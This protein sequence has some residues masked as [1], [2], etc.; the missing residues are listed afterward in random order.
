MSELTLEKFGEIVDDILT[1]NHI[2]ML[3]EMP[4]GTQDVTIIDNTE[5][6]PVIHF[7]ILLKALPAVFKKLMEITEINLAEDFINT[8][9]GMVKSEILEVLKDEAVGKESKQ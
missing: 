6:G 7:Y 2:Q 3:V 9:L 4:K 1:K 8:T 5:L